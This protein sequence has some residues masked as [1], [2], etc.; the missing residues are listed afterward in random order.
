MLCEFY[1]LLP[2]AF[3]LDSDVQNI[4]CS[5]LS[6]PTDMARYRHG[7]DSTN[8][9]DFVTDPPISTEGN[10]RAMELATFFRS[11]IGGLDQIYASGYLRSLQIG[12]QLCWATNK[13]MQMDPGLSNVPHSKAVLPSAMQTFMS[14]PSIDLRYKPS[15]REPNLETTVLESLPRMLDVG[16]DIAERMSSG[17]KVAV[18]THT[19]GGTLGLA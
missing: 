2:Y 12:Q 19:L 9:K 7:L 4:S 3:A 13:K 10:R 17:Q 16:L 1:C 8:A 11:T 14:F 15:S 18:V 6:D 5:V